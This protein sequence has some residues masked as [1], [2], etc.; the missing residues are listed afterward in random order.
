MRLIKRQSTNLRNPRGKGVS[1]ETNGEVFMD[2]KHAMR[3]PMGTTGERPQYPKEGHIRYNTDIEDI[4]FYRKGIWRRVRDTRPGN[5]FQ[6]NLG[7]GD[8]VEIDFGPLNSRDQD[9]PI[10]DKAES[11]FV[12]V[13]NV[14]QIPN[15]NYTLFQNPAGKPEG[16]YIRF[17]SPVDL[18]K[19]VTVLHNFDK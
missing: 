18:G 12:F 13:E 11:I 14:Y 10:P 15:T 5:I 19:P 16:W 4:E 1:V 8:Q 9:F 3:V 6:Q 2:S 7:A 17:S